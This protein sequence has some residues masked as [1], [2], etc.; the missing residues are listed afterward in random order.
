MICR[1]RSGAYAD[2]AR[3]GAPGAVQVADRF[4]LWQNLGKAVER[5]VAHHRACLRRPTRAESAAGEPAA[6]A[7]RGTARRPVRRTRP[8]PPRAGARPGGAG[9]R[10]AGDRPTTGLGVPHR[11]ALRP[12][13]DLAG[14]GRR[15]MARPP[16]QQA[17]PVQ[18]AAA[19]AL[20]AR[21]HQRRRLAQGNHRPGLCRQLRAGPRLP[22]AVP[23]C[24][25]PDRPATTHG[26]GGDWL[27]HPPP[28]PPDRGR[29]PGAEGD[30]GAVPGAPSGCRSRP[31]LR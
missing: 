2:G 1:D 6:A 20:P 23:A 21:L 18:A 10:Q 16:P 11:A 22:R 26:A 13:A 14:V 31:G 7:G 15:Q 24:A 28:R 4:H 27:A 29:A 12:R 8:P 3:T 30:P 17:R 5:L 25:R 9:P 19:T